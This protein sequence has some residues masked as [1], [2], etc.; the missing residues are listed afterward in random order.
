MSIP[1]ENGRISGIQLFRQILYDTIPMPA[2]LWDEQGNIIDCNNAM[3][4]FLK[5]ESKE[6]CLQ[7]FFAYATP[8]QPCGL[9]SSEK[10]ASLLKQT[11]ELG[12]AHFEW[13][14]IIDN[15]V[16][17]VELDCICMRQYGGQY[18]AMYTKDM[19]ELKRRQTAEEESRAKTKFLAR[20][21]HE[22]RTPMNA[23]LGIT[24][25]Q[26]HRDGLHADTEEAFSR[27]YSSS[28]LLLSI[29]NDILDLS[30]VEAGKME[31]L[32]AP[33][34]VASLLV[35]TVQLNLMHIGSK[36][37]EF[38]LTVNED[39]P[40]RFIGDE[41]RIKQVMN[42][43]LS[44][45]FKYTEE[46]MVSLDVSVKDIE[47]GK[48]MLTFVVQDTGQGMT[49]E[50]LNSLFEIEFTR[51]NAASNKA[52]EGSGLGMN[53]AYQLAHL[54]G[55]DIKVSSEP[56]VGTTFTILVPQ[57]P[58]DDE[59]LGKKTIA[60]LQNIET[61]QRALKRQSRL[62][63][64]HM[65]Y[66]RVLVVDDV[67]SNLYV[68]KGLLMPYKLTIETVD[69]GRAA[70][71]KVRN[72]QIYDIIF[73]DHMMPGMDGIEATKKIRDMGYEAPIIALTANTVMGQSELFIKN[74][75]S[76]FIS[77]PID[78]NRLNTYLL[79]M[80]RD[81]QPPEVLAAAA[82]DQEM[83]QKTSGAEENFPQT[84]GE[85][86]A[87]LRESFVRDAKRSAEALNSAMSQR[88]LDTSAFKIYIIH[89]HALKAALQNINE[90]ILSAIASALE[91]AGREGDNATINALTPGFLIRL[92][93]I[94]K[95]TTEN[96]A[97]QAKK[98]LAKNGASNGAS[99]TNG[100][101][102]QSNPT[103][104]PT[105]TLT[106]A[107]GPA[108]ANI[109]NAN[110]LTTTA[111]T[112]DNITAQSSSNN[113]TKAQFAVGAMPPAQRVFVVDDSDTNLILAE[114]A[115]EDFY[116]LYTM[117]SA[118]K[119]FRML[120][121]IKPN[122]ILLDIQMP[123]TDGYEAMAKIKEN[124]ALSAIPVVFLTA[125]V[126]PEITAK[127]RRLGSADIIQKPFVAE[128]LRKKINVWLTKPGNKPTVL[129]VDDTP[130]II[131]TLSRMLLPLYN[132]K[133]AKDGKEGLRLANSHTID[134]ILLDL[135]MP[136]ISGFDVLTQLKENEKTRN[137]PVIFIT[138][139]DES[140]DEEQ[141][142]LLGAVDYIKKPFVEESVLH[143]VE[144]HIHGG[145][146]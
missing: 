65:P 20:M 13:T 10:V 83:E 23:V 123:D 38:K 97:T 120:E 43:V 47:D 46:G 99:K 60:N 78:V 146:I 39:V 116:E 34:E 79:R 81:K 70:I 48:K 8:I 44:N 95:E 103:T 85:L 63:G 88:H 66:G 106:N 96:L 110:G 121:K 127:A 87:R 76:G 69:S 92:N 12:H 57:T 105:A 33:Y 132:V 17:D 139:S 98:V 42:N 64:V 18:T 124:P 128:H 93:D 6:N 49:R 113:A 9:S 77:K 50:Q 74:G 118:D 7:R 3:V 55:G 16:V 86:S 144:L 72:G 31:I 21:S 145:K 4:K 37:I 109:T 84:P 52:I 25:M 108:T 119:M 29:I 107:N 133:V 136:G 114:E 125:T 22:I 59:A 15:E 91:Q 1:T 100:N 80:I 122:L 26:M 135:H 36:S 56:N 141:G 41:V 82:R 140:D 14:H 134:L 129:I 27:I 115:L 143:R 131:S 45:A 112:N 130:M 71:H 138:G 89:T 19:R 94:I 32:D 126:T 102:T 53:I 58:N 24:E 68:A 11:A 142:F 67:E 40:A 75:F 137:L 101:T 104:K 51:F 111:P 73:M 54:M 61:A 90:P 62:A 2:T 30:K 117:D 35:D 5:C 28:N